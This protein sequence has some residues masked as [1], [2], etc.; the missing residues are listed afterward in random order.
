MM[1]ARYADVEQFVGLVYSE[2]VI[3]MSVYWLCP[4]TLAPLHLHFM[5]CA[6][7]IL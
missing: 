4:D 1:T 3:E 6:R 5:K 2:W 7:K